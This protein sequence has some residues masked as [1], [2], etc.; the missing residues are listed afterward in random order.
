MPIQNK[1]HALE[2]YIINILAKKTNDE[3]LPF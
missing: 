3:T 2:N 1:A